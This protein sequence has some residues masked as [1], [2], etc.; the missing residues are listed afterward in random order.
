M[1]ERGRG[2][3]FRGRVTFAPNHSSC[4]HFYAS[5]QFII[6]NNEFSGTYNPA[7][8][9]NAAYG[10]RCTT[11][12]QACINQTALV[13][14]FLRAHHAVD[15]LTKPCKSLWTVND[16]EQAYAY[17]TD[18]CATCIVWGTLPI[19]KHVGETGKWVRRWRP[20]ITLLDE[21]KYIPTSHPRM[22]ARQHHGALR[23][24][25]PALP[26]PRAPHDRADAGTY[27]LPTADC[28][29]RYR[30]RALYQ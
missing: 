1:K 15:R 3:Q 22:C 16:A 23:Q 29:V 7:C 2:Q 30:P 17:Q 6:A 11:P 5:L 20:P 10:M 28:G 12:T 27:H 18:F 13:S 26:F 25:G 24:H 4:S 8:A 9:A 14:F 21:T 19:C